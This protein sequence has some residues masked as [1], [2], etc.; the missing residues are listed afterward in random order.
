[1][2]AN[3]MRSYQSEQEIE[4]YLDGLPREILAELYEC[5]DGYSTLFKTKLEQEWLSRQN[6]ETGQVTTAS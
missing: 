3:P 1:M 5:R 4:N 2:S 6:F